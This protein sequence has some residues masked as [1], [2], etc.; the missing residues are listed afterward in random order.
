MQP[1]NATVIYYSATGTMHALAQAAAEAAEKAG[2]RVRLRKVGELAPQSAIN[3][4]PAWVQHRRETAKIP[5][6]A[7]EDLTWAD[8]IMLGTPTRFGT[9]V[10]QLKAFIETT[11]RCGSGASSPTRYTRRSPPPRPRT[12]V[13]RLPCSP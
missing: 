5:E 3:A 10:S 9:P 4:N 1:V 11:G 13:K 7:H 6:A 8:V 12:E 2:A